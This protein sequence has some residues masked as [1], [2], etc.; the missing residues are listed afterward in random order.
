MFLTLTFDNINYYDRVDV[1]S[2]HWNPQ[3]GGQFSETSQMLPKR[4]V[5]EMS[6]NGMKPWPG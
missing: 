3:T 2:D 1:I 5:L 4:L 6:F